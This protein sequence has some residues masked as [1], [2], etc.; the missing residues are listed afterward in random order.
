M[1]GFRLTTKVQVSGWR[2][3]LRRMEHAI[4]RRDTRMFDDPLSFYSRSVA[5]GVLISVLIVAGSAALAYFK[6]QGK[7]GGGN[8][9]IDRSTNQLYLKVSGQVHPVY[10][11]TSARLVLGNPAEPATVNPAELNTLP[12]GQ[13]I[14]IPGAP[15]ATPVV[16]DAAP[17][18]AL[19]D[20]VTAPES[21]DPG[22]Q[23]AVLSMPLDVA[24]S[25]QV[26]PNETLLATFQGKG[27]IVDM[28]G[29]HRTHL[30][31][32]VL[33]SALG[34]PMGAKPT[35]LSEAM[36]N[37]IPDAGSWELPPI[38]GAGAPNTVDLPKELVIGSVFQVQTPFGNQFYVVLPDGVARVNLNTASLLRANE[39]Y[40]LS[41]IPLM[42]KS[43]VVKI[44]ERE[45][46]SP[47]PDDAILLVSRPQEPVLC[48]IWQRAA[49]EQT[50]KTKLLTIAHLPI[51]PSAMD[52]G[53][54]QV[55]GDT[56]V[57]LD[58]GKYVQIQSPDPRYGEALY[59]IDPQGVCYGIP[60]QKTAEALGLS[61]PK[62][63]PWGA[64][65]LLVDGPVLSRDAALLE[66]STLPADPS[67]RRLPAAAG[68][69]S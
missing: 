2:F 26:L 55:Q 22:V 59:Y 1:A 48:W 34:I 61:N 3:L 68:A 56:T 44:P 69:S 41:A 45:Y 52:K 28:H 23:V 19:C 9:L 24:S 57:Y 39:S 58:G 67:P 14:G 43:Q 66:H 64:V 20:T 51:P 49:G 54:D 10:N 63:A 50:P 16:A 47:L 65:H 11:L 30:T 36:F 42:V 18:W 53:I 29:R 32:H 31:D 21:A 60:D 6:P 40:G 12:R 13:S 62:P 38:P 17:T 46:P 33:T 25:D 4:V 27:W 37:A 15:Y 35:P 8:L 5:F 7:I